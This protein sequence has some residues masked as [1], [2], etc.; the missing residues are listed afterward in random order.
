MCEQRKTA[1]GKENN[2]KTVFP[3]LVIFG[4]QLG[5]LYFRFFFVRKTFDRKYG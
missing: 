2:N 4:L 1:N 5:V 3:H